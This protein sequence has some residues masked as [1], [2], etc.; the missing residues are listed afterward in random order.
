VLLAGTAPPD[1][2]IHAAVETA[3]WLVSG[4]AHERALDRL[5]LPIEADDDPFAAIGRRAQAVRFNSRSFDDPAAALLEAARQAGADA[6]I[7]W[8]IE[9][10]E[11]MVWH[12]PPQVAT[13]AQAGIPMLVLTRRRWDGND[14]AAAEI[15]AWLAEM[16]A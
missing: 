15:A 8:L 3:G 9:Q 14:G 6:V 13:M 2:R 16:D 7:L 10:E 5:G 4:E 12:V 1:D 11:S